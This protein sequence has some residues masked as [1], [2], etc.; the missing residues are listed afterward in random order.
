MRRALF[1]RTASTRVAVSQRATAALIYGAE[2]L[3]Q[4]I[5]NACTCLVE[6]LVD[7]L[8]PPM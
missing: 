2:R 4:S 7:S 3:P 8:K 6:A 1:V 5:N